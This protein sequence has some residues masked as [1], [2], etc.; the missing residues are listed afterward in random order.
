[1]TPG[2]RQYLAE[3][4]S[5]DGATTATLSPAWQPGPR[6]DHSKLF[7]LP[8]LSQWLF[9]PEF[10]TSFYNPLKNNRVRS[11]T[12]TP[13]IPTQTSVLVSYDFCDKSPWPKQLG[14][15]TGLPFHTTIHHQRKL[16]Q[17]LKQD[18]TW[19]QETMMGAAYWY[20]LI[21]CSACSYR[22]RDH[23]PRVVLL[24]QSL[25]KKML[26]R[27]AWSPVL[28]RHFLNW[29]SPLLMILVCVKVT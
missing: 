18:R 16:E 17:E 23:E 2:C 14:E 20:A 7:S 12:A 27:L 26:Y 28:G 29:G 11:V 22:T 1:M 13:I 19:R 15:D 10:P 21:A 24:H 4:N 25:L 5:S 9:S 3:S 8:R 6:S